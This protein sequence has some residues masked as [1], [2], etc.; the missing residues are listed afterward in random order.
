MFRLVFSYLFI[1]IL[2][3]RSRRRNIPRF[4][5]FRDLLIHPI[6]ARTLSGFKAYLEQN[7]G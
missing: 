5:S 4:H 6:A 7:A 3:F 2:A 1:V